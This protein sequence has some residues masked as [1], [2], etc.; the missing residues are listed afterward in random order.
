MCLTNRF[1]PLVE[2]VLRRAPI[3][4]SDG[5]L[6]SDFWACVV[7]CFHTISLCEPANHRCSIGIGKTVKSVLLD[8]QSPFGDAL[9]PF[10]LSICSSLFLIKNYIGCHLRHLGS[11]NSLWSTLQAMQQREVVHV[12]ACCCKEHSIRRTWISHGPS[13]WMSCWSR[14]FDCRDKIALCWQW[15]IVVPRAVFL[16]LIWCRGRVCM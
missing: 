13:A 14:C 15:W 11:R 3:L 1:R 9:I 7:L 5:I 4:C 12:C 6:I 8:R 10:N 2:N 16:I